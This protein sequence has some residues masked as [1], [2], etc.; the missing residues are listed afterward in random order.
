VTRHECTSSPV[1]SSMPAQIRFGTDG[2]RGVIADDFTCDSVRICTQAIASHLNDGDG[3][4]KG[5]IVGY[6]TRFASERFANAAAEVLAANSIPVFLCQDPTPT[7]VV[8]FAIRQLAA[9]GAIIITASHNPGQY[10]GFK[11]RP[12]YAGAASDEVLAQVQA[13]I[14]RVVTGEMPVQKVELATAS[15]GGLLKTFDPWPDYFRNIASLV[16]LDRIRESS[17]RVVA[18]PMYGAGMGY[19]PR[20][21][22]GSSVAISE[23]HGERNPLFPGIRAPEP[24]GENLGELRE[25][26]VSGCADVGL[27][28]DGDADRLARVDE[29][30]RFIENFNVYPLLLYHLLAAGRAPGA[31]VKTVA[32]SSLVD[33]VAERFNVPVRVTGV[34]FKH[35]AP[36][37]LETQ[38]I[39]GGEESGGYAFGDHLPERDGILAGLYVLE[40]LVRSRRSLSGLLT[41][42]QTEF[43]P[44]YYRRMDRSFQAELGDQVDET[45]R[46]AHPNQIAG[47]S[48]TDI[49][50]IDGLRLGLIDGSW[51]L[52]RRSGTEPLIRVY[53]ES[54]S[55]GLTETLLTEG[56]R[57]IGLGS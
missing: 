7:P 36:L 9:A 56:L 5:V 12:G 48:V 18:D 51:L 28:T 30:G 34:G 37:M 45:I 1:A 33:R 19:F 29:R 54:R 20:L 57:L 6:D 2:W 23:I 50:T 24:V 4:S 55:E 14:G 44:H 47:L 22:G 40:M 35:I 39:M 49:S 42:L 46:G 13:V 53:A 15:Q 25:A 3:S 32:T 41:N 26:V 11:F 43:G 10:N 16:D 31:V 8:S 21:L 17:L 38:A 52:L 27:A